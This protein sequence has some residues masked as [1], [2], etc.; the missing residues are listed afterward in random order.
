GPGDIECD[1]VDD[2]T[3]FGSVSNEYTTDVAQTFQR[4][5]RIKSGETHSQLQLDLI[6]HLWQLHGAE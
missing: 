6:E 4:L 2:A 1:G 5:S 3:L